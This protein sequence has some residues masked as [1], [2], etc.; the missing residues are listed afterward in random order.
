MLR[1]RFLIQV[2][3]ACAVGSRGAH[4]QPAVPTIGF[5]HAGSADGSAHLA[6][7]FEQGL[8][9]AGYGVGRN[10]AIVHRWADGQND[11]LPAM[12]NELTQRRVAVIAVGGNSAARMAA[13][14][15]GSTVPVVFVSANDPVKEGLVASLNR[16]GG[17][18]T[19][20]SILSTRLDAKRFELL[21]A[22]LPDAD[23][24]AILANPLEPRTQT[25]LAEIRTAAQA[26]G[27]QVRVLNASNAR[28]I[29]AAF[30]DA[31]L[32]RVR[33]L[34]FS[35]RDQIVGLAAR[36]A[37]PAIYE[38]REFCDIGGLMS[39][40]ASITAGYRQMGAYVA[41]ILNGADPANL[42]VV[43]SDQ[44]ELVINLG[45]AG[46]LGIKVPQA[47]LLRADVVIP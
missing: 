8:R 10:V 37:I 46:A 24:V 33:A 38:W 30:K 9:E 20:V 11:R 22:M 47:L 16:P 23:P 43:Q 42:P 12:V 25:Q 18:I 7:A 1:R 36:H 28:E 32:A 2:A 45:T 40:G 14:T 17:R 34:L 6:R 26:A 35:R 44:F 15:A 41:R 5:L 27:K 31:A 39:Y 29:D 3:A 19:G 4:G 21:H 13:K